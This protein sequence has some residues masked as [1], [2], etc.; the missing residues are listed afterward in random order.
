MK[1]RKTDAGVDTDMSRLQHHKYHPDTQ[2]Y[3]SADSLD[4]T[5]Q[6]NTLQNTNSESLEQRQN[7]NSCTRQYCQYIDPGI[8]DRTHCTALP[9]R[10]MSRLQHDKYQADIQHYTFADSLDHTYQL[11]TLDMFRLQH[12]KYQADIQHYTFADSLDHT[13]QLNTLQNTNSESL[14]QRQNE[15]SCTARHCQYIDPGIPDRTYCTALPGRYMSRLQH[16]KYQAD[17][18]HYT[19]ADSLDHTY[20]LNTLQNTNSGSLEQRQNENSCTRQYCQYIDPGIPDRTYC[21][22]L[23]GRYMSRLQHDKYQADIQHYKF[24]DSLDHTYQ[25]NT[26]QNTNSGSL[27]QRQNENSC[28][29]QYCQY[30]DPGILDR[31][32]CT[33]LPGRDM[34]RLQHHKYQADIQHYTFA[35]S[36]DHTY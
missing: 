29:R 2:H 22:A 7:E 9:V 21:T 27:E 10:Y 24:P 13:Y 18:Q 16:D 11:N 25:L 32:L 14:E 20:Q 8:P 1:M 23:P 31:T 30:I 12:H 33:A 4:H 26:L 15:N 5:Y 28:T 19:F 36:L 35:D 6:L 17:I 34:F 3:N